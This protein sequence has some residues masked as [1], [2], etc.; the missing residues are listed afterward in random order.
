M[1]ILLF[2][3]TSRRTCVPTSLKGLT[4]G[5]GGG[6]VEASADQLNQPEHRLF[7]NGMVCGK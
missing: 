3:P 4:V 6:G 1:A 2:E 5:G 7:P